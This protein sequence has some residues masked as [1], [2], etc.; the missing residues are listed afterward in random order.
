MLPQTEVTLL[1]PFCP[2]YNEFMA[3]TDHT[4]FFMS[5]LEILAHVLIFIWQVLLHT[6]HDSCLVSSMFKA[7]NLILFSLFITKE[8]DSL[9]EN[10]LYMLRFEYLVYSSWNSLGKIESVALLKEVC[11]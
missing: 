3:T 2:H 8:S 6:E 1:F 4:F 11:Y 5:T 10:Y 7:T 9:K